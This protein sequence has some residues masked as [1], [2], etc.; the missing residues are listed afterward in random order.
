[1]TLAKS[2][3]G[4]VEK[5]L[6]ATI[7]GLISYSTNRSGAVSC[8]RGTSKRLKSSQAKIYDLVKPALTPE[9]IL[10]EDL[11]KRVMSPLLERIGRKDMPARRLL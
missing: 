6:R 2:D 5:F 10:N 8:W 4:L 9:G 7:S 3:P 1:M 11:Q